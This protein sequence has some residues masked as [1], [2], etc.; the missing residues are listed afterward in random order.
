MAE[1]HELSD[2]GCLFTGDTFLLAA[3]LVAVSS[4]SF[5]E[6]RITDLI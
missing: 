4:V 6:A 2:D 5:N 3:D 1:I